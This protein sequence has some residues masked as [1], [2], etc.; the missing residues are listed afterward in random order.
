MSQSN[1]D[2]IDFKINYKQESKNKLKESKNTVEVNIDTDRV[3]D[4]SKYYIKLARISDQGAE[5]IY[6]KVIDIKEVKNK[7][8]NSTKEEGFILTDRE[9]ILVLKNIPGDKYEVFVRIDNSKGEIF[10]HW[11]EIVLDGK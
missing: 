11:K 2:A 9:L 1:S 10:T 7:E 5:D 4:A 3:K 8:A 6:Q